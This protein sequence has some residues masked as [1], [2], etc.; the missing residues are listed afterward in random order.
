MSKPVITV[1]DLRVAGFT[2][3]NLLHEIVDYVFDVLCDAV[4]QG[5]YRAPVEGDDDFDTLWEEAEAIAIRLDRV[6]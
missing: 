6:L 2:S 1:Q 5:Q 4:R 3:E